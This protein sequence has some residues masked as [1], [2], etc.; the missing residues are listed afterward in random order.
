MA[1][2]ERV[3]HASV[4]MTASSTL[5]ISTFRQQFLTAPLTTASI[6]AV[7]AVVLTQDDLSNT[8][9]AHIRHNESFA[10]MLP[11]FSRGSL[12]DNDTYAELRPV[13]KVLT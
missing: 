7:S 3:T 4:E 9:F 12:R 6:L 2:P 5:V 11:N 8:T 1:A 10:R 13:W